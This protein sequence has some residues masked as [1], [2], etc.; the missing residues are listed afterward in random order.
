MSKCLNE[1]Q[2]RAVADDEA[3]APERQHAETCGECRARADAARRAAHEL[4]SM[5][6]TLSVPVSVSSASL[7]RRRPRAGATTL[8]DVG[9][10]RVR[11]WLTTGAVAA[12]TLLVVFALPPLDAPRAIS[13]AEILDRSLQTLNI[14]SGVE[15]REF[16]LDVTLPSFGAARNG[17]YR[18]E[19]LVDHDAP[20]RYRAV[21]YAPDGTLVEGISENPAARR[22]TVV[23]NVDG[24]PFAFRLA[25]PSSR[26][27]SLR[28][29]ERHHIQAVIRLLQATAGQTLREIED[30]G[31]KRYLVELPTVASDASESGLWEL[32]RARA[33]IDAKDFQIL[34]LSA[35]G[36]YLGEP[37]SVAFRLRNR[38]T[39]SSAEVPPDQFE[40]PAVP[41]AI[42]L[43]GVSTDDF[44]RDLLA[45]ALRELARSRR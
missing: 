12:A 2:I 18:I 17:T 27:V 37:V 20:G 7:L 11:L 5:V 10:P 9:R 16:D 23:L 8:R 28:D 41:S 45:S 21:R 19:Q 43:E 6:A 15:L 14:T 39:W 30:G 38:Q 36:S 22:R 25:S 34:E 31:T 4:S 26:T 32:D 44:G 40:L 3:A 1:A 35:A 29:I 24:Q 33:V 42:T 13:A